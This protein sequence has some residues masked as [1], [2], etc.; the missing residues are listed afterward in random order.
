M[1]RGLI[2]V[3]VFFAFAVIFTLS[4]HSTPT[5]TTFAPTTTTTTSV[6]SSTSTTVATSSTTCTGNEFT[7]T[8]NQ[9]Q[10]AAGT[11]YA[12]VT[13]TKATAGTCT[14]DGWPTLTLQ[15]RTGGL[16][17]VSLAHVPSSTDS[18]QFSVPKANELPTALT[19]DQGSL[20]NFSLAY[21]QV[22]TGNTAC[23]SAVTIS[24]QFVK[25]QTSIAVTPP[26]PI[27]PCDAG[28]VW[29]SP[30]Y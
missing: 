12:S 7:G 1:R 13:L 5:T 15:D 2:S 21:S 20:T 11:V 4:R 9:G 8:F 27:T 10:G 18:V 19:L 22:Q 24:V 30:F 23:E 26:Y 25:F 29:V 28:K 3:A 17:A 16:L 14:V 6:S